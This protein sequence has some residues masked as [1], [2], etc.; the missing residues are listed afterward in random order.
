MSREEDKNGRRVLAR[1]ALRRANAGEEFRLLVDCHYYAGGGH[2][3]EY[4]CFSVVNA[5]LLKRLPAAQPDELVSLY[6]SDF[7]GP[8]YCASSLLDYVDLRDRADVLSGLIAYWRQSVRIKSVEQAE[9]SITADIVT[10]NY[11]DGIKACFQPFGLILP[12]NDWATILPSS[13][14][15]VSVPTSYTLS[16][17]SAV[18]RM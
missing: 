17:V 4:C 7:S 6:T 8:H 1:P 15:N 9:D 11:F 16:A 3:R 10:D 5:V 13:T 14:T 18:H 12:A 2:R